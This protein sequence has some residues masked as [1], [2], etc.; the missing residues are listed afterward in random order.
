MESAGDAYCKFERPQF[1]LKMEFLLVMMIYH[2]QRVKK[3]ISALCTEGFI[4][5]SFS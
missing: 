3:L 5:L 1:M 4:L 2:V